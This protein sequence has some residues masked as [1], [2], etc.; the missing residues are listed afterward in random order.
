MDRMAGIDDYVAQNGAKLSAYFVELLRDLVAARTVNVVAARL[1]EFPYLTERGEETRAVEIIR[2]WAEKEGF[3]TETHARIP[4]RENIVLHYG[5]R[6]GSKL[7]V[8]GHTDVVPPGEGWDGDPFALRRNGDTV[9][10]RGATDDKGPLAAS[11]LALKILKDSGTQ[12]AGDLQ[13]GGLADEEA[14]DQDGIDYGLV[15][16]LENGLIDADYAVVPDIGGNMRDIDIAEKGI[17]NFEIHARGRQAHGSTPEK[18]VNAI[19]GMAEYLLRLKE[20]RFQY[21]PH[22]VLGGY[23]VN[24]GQIEGGAAPNIVPGGCR[25]VIDMRILPS[26]TV[27]GVKKELLGLAEGLDCN[28]SIEVKMSHDP[29]EIEP[30]SKLIEG[31]KSAARHV[32]G[33][34]PRTMGLGGGTYAK[35]LNHCGIEAVGFGPGSSDAMHMANESA[36]IAEHLGFAHVLAVL[37]VE[38]AG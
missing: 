4:E 6:S 28:F 15:Y 1:G 14:T 3:E 32:L 27:E 25:A 34:T 20:H 31:V 17:V 7:L 13:V 35:F 10:G 21:E 36:S 24:V 11:M 19:D 8:P 23:T 18:G 5:E 29:H 22:P 33:E 37:A 16:M 38:L 9:I 2:T 26:Q 30:D 12:I